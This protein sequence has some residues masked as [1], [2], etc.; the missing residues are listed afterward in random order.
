MRRKDREITDRNTMLDIIAKTQVC[1]LGMS[2][3]NMPY[4]LPINLGL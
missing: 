1:Y 2:N 4:V 3:E